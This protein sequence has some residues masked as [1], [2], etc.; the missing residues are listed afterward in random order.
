MQIMTAWNLKS[1]DT[2]KYAGKSFPVGTA[3][4]MEWTGEYE[5]RRYQRAPMVRVEPADDPGGAFM[6][7]GDA[8]ILVTPRGK[9]VKS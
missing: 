6:L 2:M 7:P 4:R 8:V 9:G 5:G 1:G 3:R